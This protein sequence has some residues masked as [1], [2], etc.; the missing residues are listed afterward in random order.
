MGAALPLFRNAELEALRQKR[1][2]LLARLSRKRRFSH[3]RLEL[4]GRLKQV[5]AEILTLEIELSAAGPERRA[6]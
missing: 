1:T 2:A 5:T 4:L 3:D 6:K